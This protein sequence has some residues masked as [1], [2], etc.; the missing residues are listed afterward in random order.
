[1]GL[2]LAKKPTNFHFQGSRECCNF[3]IHREPLPIFQSG[4]R[5][6]CDLDTEASQSPAQVFLRYLRLDSQSRDPHT[7]PNH[8][9]EFRGTSPVHP[10]PSYRNSC[11]ALCI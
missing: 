3:I 7:I 2:S 4:E 8:I 10:P 6:L 9:L 1:M 5:C 11:S